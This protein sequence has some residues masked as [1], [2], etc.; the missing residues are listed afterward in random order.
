MKKNNPGNIK[1][2]DASA[3][4][5]MNP[6]I[7]VRSSINTAVMLYVANIPMTTK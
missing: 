1:L 5:L 7:S 6:K 3:N 4:A 2:T